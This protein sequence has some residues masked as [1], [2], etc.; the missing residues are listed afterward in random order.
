MTQIRALILLLGLGLTTGALAEMRTY[1]VEAR[2]RQEVYTALRGVLSP[3]GVTP[4]QG[5]IQ[6]LPTGQLLIDTSAEMHAQ[7]AAVLQSIKNH[8]AEATPRVTLRYWAVLGTKGS[9]QDSRIGGDNMEVPEILSGV[10]DELRRVHG[11]LAFRL[12]GNATLVSE[13]GQKGDLSGETLNIS[14]RAYVQESKL[15]VELEIDAGYAL[16]LSHQVGSGDGQTNPFRSFQRLQQGV[17][18][19][20]SLEPNEFVVVGENTIRYSDRVEGGIDGTV[21][22]IVQWSVAK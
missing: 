14:Q 5:R 20:T 6:L 22:Y 15:N 2:Y 11:D 16:L 10:L 19:N 8:Q 1:D 18:L 21:F 13:S 9:P 4:P 3:E 12:Y 17:K 7:V